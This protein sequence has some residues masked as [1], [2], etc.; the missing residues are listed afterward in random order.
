LNQKGITTVVLI[1]IVVGLALVAGIAY[2]HSLGKLGLRAPAPE[3]SNQITEYNSF[4]E[5]DDVSSASSAIVEGMDNPKIIGITK[6]TKNL[7]QLTISNFKKPLWLCT[8]QDFYSKPDNQT[9]NSGILVSSP[10]PTFEQN[11]AVSKDSSERANISA[12]ALRLYENNK[13][14]TL[15]DAVIAKDLDSESPALA[16]L[17]KLWKYC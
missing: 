16:P 1:L 8:Q 10:N 14:T 6:P 3:V 15:Y 4:P 17:A 2:Y 9:C 11:Y 5:E 7:Y 12:A 13:L